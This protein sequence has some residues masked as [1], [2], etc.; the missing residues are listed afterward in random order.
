MVGSDPSGEAP[1]V[2]RVSEKT[3]RRAIAEGPPGAAKIRGDPHGGA[4]RIAPENS[5]ACGDAPAH[6][7]LKALYREFL[8]AK[9]G[10][11]AGMEPEPRP[12][13][14]N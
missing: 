4:R 3:V 8:A 9:S 14:A 1:H 11:L 5:G 12:D 7:T 13:Q 6:P 10:R 2:T